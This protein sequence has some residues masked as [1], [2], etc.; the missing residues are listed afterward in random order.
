M[1]LSFLVGAAAGY[2]LGAKAGRERY[3]TIVR[4]ARRFAGSQTVQSTRGVLQAQTA[5]MRQSLKHAV[6]QALTN[7]AQRGG[8]GGG[9]PD[10]RAAR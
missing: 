8:G 4:V 10:R 2:V 7:S 3:E 9:Y 6:G 5:S 1:K